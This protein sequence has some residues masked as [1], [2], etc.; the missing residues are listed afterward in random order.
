MLL[1]AVQCTASSRQNIC[2]MD[3]FINMAVMKIF[4]V[5][6]KNCA[7]MRDYLD[8]NDVAELVKTRYAK[9]LTGLIVNQFQT[10]LLK[11]ALTNCSLL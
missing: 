7:L 8:P 4:K 3:R 6:S 2:M 9:F 10:E 1:Y 5:S 11:I